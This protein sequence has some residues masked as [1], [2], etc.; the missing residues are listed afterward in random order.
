MK[1][2]LAYV[3]SFMSVRQY[4]LTGTIMLVFWLTLLFF[5]IENYF[6]VITH[7]VLGI[8]IGFYAATL[9]IGLFFGMTD[10][11]KSVTKRGIF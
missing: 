3:L 8:P 1:K 11:L 2:I 7:S 6:L 4:Y 10:F 9:A 5:Q